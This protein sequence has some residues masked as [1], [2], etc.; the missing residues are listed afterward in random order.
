LHK[1]IFAKVALPNE[2]G[3]R[4]SAKQLIEIISVVA[5][6]KNRNLI[7]TDEYRGYKTLI[8][9]DFWH[10][11]IDH[12][13]AFSSPDGFFHTNNAESFWAVLK[14]GVYGVYHHI[15]VKYMQRYVDEFCF[16]YNNR[17]TDMFGVLLRQSILA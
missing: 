15:S 17:D 6:W 3:N 12:S 13:K 11:T 14:R 4:L 5:K 7:I 8:D 2:K 10:S 16:R 1:K 9:N